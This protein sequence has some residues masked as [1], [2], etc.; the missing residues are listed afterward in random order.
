M[1]ASFTREHAGRAPKAG[2]QL[3]EEFEMSTAIAFAV[4]L[5]PGKTE[6][7]RAAMRSCWLGERRT[8]HARS[9]RRMGIT[10]EAVWIQSTPAGDVAVV[11]LVADDVE[12]AFKA[13]GA[14]DEPFDTWFREHC[15]D[16]HGID[17]AVDIPVAEQVLDYRG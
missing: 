7:D 3:S 6:T 2:V 4:P 14:S 10:S 15:R 1:V 12:T 17:I 11:R 8:E 13:M 16:V 5:L 9:R